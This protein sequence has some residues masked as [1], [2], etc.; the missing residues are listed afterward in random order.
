MARR[1]APA[2]DP[3]R[4]LIVAAT[5]LGMCVGAAVSKD[6]APG[7]SSVGRSTRGDVRAVERPAAR[8]PRARLR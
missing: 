5:V 4:K 8:P 6:A 3:P 2:L 1:K 7:E